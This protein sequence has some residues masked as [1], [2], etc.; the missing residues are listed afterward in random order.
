MNDSDD[1]RRAGK[2][3]WEMTWD[4]FICPHY[5]GAQFSVDGRKDEDWEWIWE[6]EQELI[7]RLA[8]PVWTSACGH[9]AIR[10]FKDAERGLNIMLVHDGREI[11]GFYL[12]CM[13]WVDPKHRKQGLGVELV[14]QAIEMLGDS[15]V[16]DEEVLG[17]TK[18]GITVMKKAHKTVIEK[19]VAAGEQVPM[20]VL[21]SYKLDAADSI[22][23]KP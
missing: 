20:R 5:V 21:K 11:A 12:N 3:P 8:P 22:A 15:P 9:Y 14:V 4:E 19:A 1:D 16:A 6:D 17:F 7:E 10:E 23:P 13:L 2:K 18:A